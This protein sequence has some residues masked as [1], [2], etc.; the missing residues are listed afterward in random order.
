MTC[1]REAERTGDLGGQDELKTSLLPTRGGR[2]IVVDFK[3]LSNDV[4][5]D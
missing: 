5:E 4:V 1:M 2:K 3:D